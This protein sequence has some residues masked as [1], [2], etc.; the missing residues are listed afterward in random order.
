MPTMHNSLL[1]FSKNYMTKEHKSAISAIRLVMTICVLTV[2][3]A[4]MA[5]SQWQGCD[6]LY[7][8]GV[9]CFAQSGT[10]IFAGTIEGGIFLST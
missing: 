2:F 4:N 7:G 8:T 9:K 6:K 5:H 3:Y 1:T 10:N